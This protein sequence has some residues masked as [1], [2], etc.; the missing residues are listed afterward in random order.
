[1]LP[2]GRQWASALSLPLSSMRFFRS[3]AAHGLSGKPPSSPKPMS[4]NWFALG[5]I[6]PS[7]SGAPAAP[8]TPASPPVPNPRATRQ[9]PDSSGLP[10]AV[11]GAGAVRLGLPSEVLGTRA[12]A[13]GGHCAVIASKPSTLSQAFMAASRSKDL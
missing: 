11:L 1:M 2:I 8:P 10:S 9:M 6:V 3:A 5:G 12:V 13:Y 7:S 4:Q